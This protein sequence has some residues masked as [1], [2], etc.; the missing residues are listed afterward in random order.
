M[1]SQWTGTNILNTYQLKARLYPALLTVAPILGV[2]I[3]YYGVSLDLKG[4]LL[5]LFVGLGGLYL[6]ANIVREYGK[7]LEVRL[8]KEWGGTPTTQLQRHRDK[9]VNAHTKAGRHR[10]LAGKIGIPYPDASSELVDPEAADDVYAAGTGWLIEHTRERP[11]FQLLFEENVAYGY[12]RNTRALKPLGII[13]CLAAITWVLYSASVINQLGFNREAAAVLSPGTLGSLL[14]SLLILL[15]WVF[16][17][18]KRTVR[19]A[20]FTYA[21]RLLRACELLS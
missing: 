9:A 4:S 10:F 3:G 17:F 14:F 18:T 20:A 15:V 2:A 12:R 11:Q 8:Y 21:D 6:V 16:Y 7:S 5:S 1:Q 13:I 19:T